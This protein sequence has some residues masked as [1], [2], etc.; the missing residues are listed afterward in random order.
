MLFHS[1]VGQT[2]GF[3]AFAEQL[4]AGG[5]L[6]T[7]P[8]LFEG[9]TFSSVQEGSAHAEDVGLDKVTE[10]GLAAAEGLPPEVVYAGVSMGVL[11][12]QKLAQTRP[13]ARGAVFM[14]SCLP[15]N[16]FA[17]SWPSHL[18]V[19]VH[20]MDGDPYFAGEGDIDNARALVA[21]AE[22]GQLFTYRGDQHLFTDSSL[23][24]YDAEAASL[25]LSRVLTFLA[26]RSR[27][28]L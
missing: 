22:E 23:P 4:R 2:P 14:E 11:S 21:S 12:A 6:V 25:V 5:H 28:A 20:G 13:G 3:L 17:D 7:T 1:A 18:P 8:D 26:A 10:A 27:S 16:Y 19:Q 9:R 15:Q 24:S